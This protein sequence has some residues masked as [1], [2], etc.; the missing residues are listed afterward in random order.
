[1]FLHGASVS[2]GLD[3]TLY[4]QYSYYEVIKFIPKKLNLYLKIYT[5]VAQPLLYLKVSSVIIFII[6]QVSKFIHSSILLVKRGSRD[7]HEIQLLTA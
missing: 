5:F 3:H 4:L 1:M 2:I 6:Y 7:S